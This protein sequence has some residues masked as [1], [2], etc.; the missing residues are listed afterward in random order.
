[1]LPSGRGWPG[2]STTE[3]VGAGW[4]SNPPRIALTNQGMRFHR[5]VKTAVELNY[6]IGAVV[7]TARVEIG[8]RPYRKTTSSRSSVGED[9]ECCTTTQS[10]TALNFSLCG[11]LKGVNIL[12]KLISYKRWK[13]GGGV[14]KVFAE[15]EDDPGRTKTGMAQA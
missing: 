6:P 4:E 8:R 10:S 14:S 5:G 11:K 7:T 13:P 12:H 15:G 9:S 2:A 1:M 3:V